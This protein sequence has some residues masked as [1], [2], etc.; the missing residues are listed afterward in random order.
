[1]P[2]FVTMP[3]GSNSANKGISSCMAKVESLAKGLPPGHWVADNVTQNF[4]RLTR[5]TIIACVVTKRNFIGA[6]I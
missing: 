3:I 5:F 6:I 2:A 4:N 1:M